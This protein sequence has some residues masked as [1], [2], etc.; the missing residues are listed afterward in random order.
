[1]KTTALCCLSLTFLASALPCRA[2][3]KFADLIVDPPLIRLQGPHAGYQLL[4]HGKEADGPASDD[5]L[6]DLTHR[7]EYR[8]GNPGIVTVSAK[9]F[10]RAVSD[11]NSEVH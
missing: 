3:E 5:R 6:I 11:G 7:A 4:V 1:M 9:G 8:S 10:L 2:Q